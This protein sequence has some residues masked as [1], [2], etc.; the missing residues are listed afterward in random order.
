MLLFDIYGL[1]LRSFMASVFFGLQLIL[2]ETQ[3]G[4]VMFVVMLF[5]VNWEVAR[6][7]SFWQLYQTSSPPSSD[8]REG[9]HHGENV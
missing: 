8:W 3:E 1:Y 2:P 7:L 4:K 9:L 6:N 5:L